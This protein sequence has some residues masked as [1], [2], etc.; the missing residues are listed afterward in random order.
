MRHL[1]ELKNPRPDVYL[2]IIP[3]ILFNGGAAIEAIVRSL[4]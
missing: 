3:K 4:Q 1:G 2:R